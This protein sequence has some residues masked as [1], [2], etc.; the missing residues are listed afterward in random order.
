MSMDVHMAV[1]RES[2]RR[3]RRAPSTIASSFV[4][5]VEHELSEE[6]WP[7]WR[8]EEQLSDYRRLLEVLRNYRRELRRAI[9]RGGEGGI[10]TFGVLFLSVSC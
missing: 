9:A 3:N 1:R 5:V 6:I 2:C 4:W 8:N 10:R 7:G